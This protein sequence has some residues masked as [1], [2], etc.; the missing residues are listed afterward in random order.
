LTDISIIPSIWYAHGLYNTVIFLLFVWQGWLGSKIRIGRLAGGPPNITVIRRH[1]RFG[2]VV[3]LLGIAGFL[4]GVVIVYI[5]GGNIL[6]R[7][8]HFSVGTVLTVSIIVA[9]FFSRKIKG[10][11]S[12]WRTL[13]FAAGTVTVCLYVIQIYLG[14][15]ILS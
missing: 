8:L 4:S 5:G 7:P 1:R 6:A 11:S 12:R 15:T 3:F 13:H 2:P 9:F 10:R 14:I